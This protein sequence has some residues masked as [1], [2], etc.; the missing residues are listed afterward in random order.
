M[1]R[2]NTYCVANHGQKQNWRSQPAVLLAQN[3]SDDVGICH[4]LSVLVDAG[5][6][7]SHYFGATHMLASLYQGP[8]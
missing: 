5:G 3:C 4:T 7:H 8:A 1:E 2:K 6:C